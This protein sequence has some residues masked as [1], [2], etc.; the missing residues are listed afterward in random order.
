MVAD[1]M[2]SRSPRIC[3]ELSA[4]DVP[5]IYRHEYLQRGCR[6][7]VALPLVVGGEPAGCFTLLAD[8]PDYFDE[9][10]MRLLVELA[11]DISFALDHIGKV[12]RLNY[13][14]SFDP[15]TGLANRQEFARRVAQYVEV[16]SHTETHFAVVL[17][18]PENFEALNNTLGRAIGDELLRQAATRFAEAAGGRDVAGHIGSDQ[19]AAI[20]SGHV[21]GSGISRLLEALWRKWLGKPFKVDGQA[22]ELT[23]KAG[24][25][26]Y[27]ADGTT[28]EAL[29]TNA[30]AA[31]RNAKQ[32]GRS[33]GFYARHLSERIAERLALER[34]LRRALDHGEYQLH[35]QPKVDLIHRRV[36]GMEALLRWKRPEH[37]MVSP[38]AFIPLLEETG[39]IVDVGAWALR[40]ACMDRQRLQRRGLDAPRVAVNVSAVQLRRDDFVR[41]LGEVVRTD[42][43][44]TGLDIEVTESV[45]MD[46]VGENLIKLEA[47]RDFGV[48]IALD[49]FGTGYSS[50]AYLAKLPVGVLKIDRSF[51]AS[52]S[53]DPSVV[54]LVSSVISLARSMKL[55]TVAE[56]VETEEQAKIL[57]MLGCD[58]MQ[59][60]LIARPMA[61]AELE[62]YL[63]SGEA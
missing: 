20:V 57:R 59:G 37:G 25:A 18:D 27:P 49:D 41:T 63:E 1:G 6:S 45:L 62:R 11:D 9:D 50:L 46:D 14:A 19:F 10:E 15:L 8:V 2:L 58:Q 42:G 16:A 29:L 30:A 44:A 22:I 55:V 40:Q 33:V 51:I 43:P 26:L 7:M 31:L 61:Y 21:E 28:A 47:A 54:T 4:P 48:G 17:A 60:Y 5:V 3:N 56:G 24:V 39:M 12:E 35:Y 38:G 13:L 52:M 32:A 23:A 53:E 34:D 36:Q